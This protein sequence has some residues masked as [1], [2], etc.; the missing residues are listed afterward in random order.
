MEAICTRTLAPFSGKEVLEPGFLREW[1]LD[2]W[3]VPQEAGVVCGQAC[4]RSQDQGK[5]VTLG[6][7]G[8]LVPLKWMGV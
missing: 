1:S 8:V 2:N 6:K 3:N 7:L 5:L 4:C